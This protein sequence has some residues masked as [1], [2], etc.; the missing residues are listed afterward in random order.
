[1]QAT[2]AEVTPR[3]S[4]LHPERKSAL[5]LNKRNEREGHMAVYWIFLC[6][7]LLPF[8]AGVIATI[9]H[10]ARERRCQHELVETGKAGARSLYRCRLCGATMYEKGAT[11]EIPLMWNWIFAVVFL[12]MALVTLF[13]DVLPALTEGKLQHSV[14]RRDTAPG[15]Y[16]SFT[17]LFAGFSAVALAACIGN[18][19][20][21]CRKT[22]GRT[23]A[24]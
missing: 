13:G 8:S 21:A 24:P 23:V 7:I 15:I 6:L 1:M 3:A 11:R 10:S 16:W 19:W 22:R 9:T 20:S 4:R 2:I 17:V 18:L 5:I 12:G 14:V